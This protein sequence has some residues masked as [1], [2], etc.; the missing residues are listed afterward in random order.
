MSPPVVA[1]LTIGAVIGLPVLAA[2]PALAAPTDRH[3]TRVS[4]PTPGSS[5][6]GTHATTGVDFTAGVRSIAH[7]AGIVTLTGSVP[8]GAS[9]E[10]S[11]DVVEPVW[12]EGDAAGHWEAQVRVRPGQHVIRVTSQVSGQAV[13][14][15]VELLILLPPDMLATVDGIAR[16]IDLAGSG[17]PGAHLVVRADGT[18]RAET[19]VAEDGTWHVLLRDLAFGSHHVEVSQYFDG[20]QNGGV[21]DVY[22]IS[23]APT[24]ERAQASRQTERITLAGRAPAGSTLTFEDAR[25]P[26][27]G[28][29]GQ[30]VEVRVGD[31]TSW[32]ATLPVPDDVRFDVVTV[33]AHDGEH[34][35]GRTDAHVTIPPRAHR[36]RGG[37]G[38]RPD[39][40]ERDRR[41]R[42][43]GHARGRVGS[44]TPRCRREAAPYRHRPELG[45][46]RPPPRPARRIRDRPTAGAGRR[47]GRAPTGAARAA[48]SARSGPRQRYRNGGRRPAVASSRGRTPGTR[49]PRGSGPMLL[50][51]VPTVGSPTP[52]RTSGG[53]P[54]Q[55]SHCSS[56]VR[57][58]CHSPPSCAA[59]QPPA[60][61]RPR[62]RSGQ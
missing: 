3:T 47:A 19:D 35:L 54:R 58:D 57:P 4:A 23:G 28:P 29:D 62:M 27:T 50:D 15:P 24:V 22:E 1:A 59:G 2:D 40:P 18:T 38:R 32:Q 51:P 53:R 13:D 17:H 12:T 49:R 37:A 60:D 26:V 8:T 48:G 10:V 61:E 7:G 36:Q 25:G 45:T 44:R 33:I 43:H 11:G 21:D 16:T 46:G 52:V 14:I 41:S 6:D 30:P 56:A 5:S 42:R 20:T 34:E 31:D 39:P 9:V 55:P